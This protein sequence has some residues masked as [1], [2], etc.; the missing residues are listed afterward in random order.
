M[1]RFPS[2]W[3]PSRGFTLVELLVVIA[4]I[5]IL[6]A[7][8][9]P[10]VQTAREA[11]RRVQCVNS[12]KQI[13]LG[14]HNHISAQNSLPVGCGRVLEDVLD[15]RRNFI[16]RGLFT[17]LLPY[18]EE[19]PVYDQ[20]V[21]D[22]YDQGRS[23]FDD[24]ARDQVV[25]PYLCPSYPEPHVIPGTSDFFQYQWG[26][27]VSYSGVG[28]AVRG[29]DNDNL[30]QS[31]FGPIPQNGAFLM[32]ETL[33][34]GPIS[35]SDREGSKATSSQRRYEQVVPHW[36]VCAS[37]LRIGDAPRT[38]PWQRA[39]L[40]YC[41]LRRCSLFIQSCRIPAQRMRLAKRYAL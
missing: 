23:Y 17:E 1:Y 32:T 38:G 41:G 25:T 35:A 31:G 21:F 14:I 10:A 13:G 20:V 18:M 5:G 28:G 39:S 26:A 4:I 30:V 7:L 6:V 12:M 3:S 16:K 22:Y 37:Q 19:Q 9:L 27:L 2:R 15:A 8:L 11:A 29:T 36:G 24:P 40:V 34:R 33:V